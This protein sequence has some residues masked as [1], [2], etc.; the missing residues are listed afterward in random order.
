MK[1]LLLSLLLFSLYSHVYA[2]TNEFQKEFGISIGMAN[3]SY[4]ETQSG[5]AGEN[6]KQPASGSTSNM[7]LLAFY[8]FLPGLKRSAYLYS[9][10]PGMSSG[11]STY[12]SVGAGMEFYFNEIG[13]RMSMSNSGTTIRVTPRLRYFWGFEGGVGYISYLTLTEK[14]TDFLMDL[15]LMGGGTYPINDKWALRMQL[16]IARGTG[17]NTT[18][19]EMKAFLGG[20]FYLD[21]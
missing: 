16:T 18:A 4:T 14:R 21:N 15:G 6:I 8:K 12:F 2:Q 11:Q 1:K 17:I 19:M 3:I 20:T 7:S 5:L 9:T 10:L 13:S